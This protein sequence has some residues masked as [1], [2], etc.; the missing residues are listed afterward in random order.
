MRFIKNNFLWI[1]FL[2]IL[3]FTSIKEGIRYN[4]NYQRKVESYIKSDGKCPYYSETDEEYNRLCDEQYAKGM[5]IKYDTV[6]L[7]Y[8]LL[9]NTD[10][11]YNLIPVFPILLIAFS[12]KNFYKEL[13]SGMFRNILFK[14]EYKKYIKKKILGTW[15]H[16][17]LLPVYLLFNFLVAFIISG[18]FDYQA[19]LN[20]YEYPP[21][22]RY[23]YSNILY[24]VFTYVVVILLHSL[25]WI[26]LGLITMRKSRNYVAAVILGYI[27]FLAI[28]LGLEIIGMIFFKKYICYFL[29]GVIWTYESVQLPG[30]LVYAL[31]LAIISSIFVYF[32]YRNKEKVIII[33]E[34]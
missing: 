21:M 10:L 9:N 24:F 12:I 19:V 8:Y 17:L 7:S 27:L 29:I 25:F 31:L 2:F 18:H 3:C 34:T 28:S 23:L 30:M 6:T 32:L 11:F 20:Y 4:E 15:K 1:I 16:A 22:D 14:E 33:H 13:K 26:N 5:P